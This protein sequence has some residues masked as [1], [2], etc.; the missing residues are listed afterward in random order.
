MLLCS[1]RKGEMGVTLHGYRHCYHHMPMTLIYLKYPVR[2]LLVVVEHLKEFGLYSGLKPEVQKTCLFPL[3]P[4]EALGKV[5]S[6]VMSLQWSLRLFRY[7]WIQ[8]YHT[9]RDVLKGNLNKTISTARE[10]VRFWIKLPLLEMGRFPIANM[11]L[12]PRLLCFFATV[13]MVIPLRYFR[14]VN[15]CMS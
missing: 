12:L 13:P 10:S 2:D 9:P 5:A 14:D 15:D 11:V 6:P 8:V 1:G 3:R 7:L 4:L